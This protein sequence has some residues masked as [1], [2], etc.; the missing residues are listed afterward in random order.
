MKDKYKIAGWVGG[1]MIA[2][3]LFLYVTAVGQNSTSG[4]IQPFGKIWVSNGLTVSGSAYTNPNG[5]FLSGNQGDFLTYS[6]GGGA[7]WQK[8]SGGSGTSGWVNLFDTN[9]GLVGS[10]TVTASQTT[11]TAG[12]P[13]T[14]Q[15]SGTGAV[16][17]GTLNKV[18][19]LS[20]TGIIPTFF[21][22]GSGTTAGTPTL[23][24]TFLT[25]TTGSGTLQIVSG[26]TADTRT[27]NYL[28]RFPN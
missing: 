8:A 11:G 14:T 12:S 22:Y 16:T 2:T 25:G 27:F 15:I 5:N 20:A 10:G 26:S 6:T 18:V 17:T 13:L 9:S 1:V 23:V 7:L 24:S 3:G 19:A 4:S 28:I 21:V